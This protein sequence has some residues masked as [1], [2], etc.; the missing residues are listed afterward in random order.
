MQPGALQPQRGL[1]SPCVAVLFSISCFCILNV[2]L[3]CHTVSDIPHTRTSTH[4]GHPAGVGFHN[5]ISW[6]SPTSSVVCYLWK[7]K[8]RS[9]KLKVVG[10]VSGVRKR[11]SPQ[12]K[13]F[14][15]QLECGA[16]VSRGRGFSMA[17]SCSASH[18]VVVWNQIMF[19]EKGLSCL[20]FLTLGCLGG[21]RFDDALID[22]QTSKKSA[23]FLD[24][25]VKGAKVHRGAPYAKALLPC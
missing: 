9:G 20:S 7:A 17:L 15:C 10:K 3:S 23:S 12:D 5:R 24:S 1:V 19:F 14:L 25:V 4:T 18:H 8:F 11:F 16:R 13:V 6:R 2:C 21:S 22:L